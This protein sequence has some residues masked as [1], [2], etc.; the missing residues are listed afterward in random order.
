[1]NQ[2]PGSSD[3]R[4]L[5]ADDI[6]RA[7]ANPDTVLR[8]RVTVDSLKSFVRARLDCA[9]SETMAEGTDSWPN[10]ALVFLDLPAGLDF[11]QVDGMDDARTELRSGLKQSD[12]DAAI[13]S[14]ATIVDDGVRVAIEDVRIDI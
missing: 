14:A 12:I 9:F 10:R 13:A 1:M 11:S 7:A 6:R 2:V 5:T 8:G 3:V 4:I